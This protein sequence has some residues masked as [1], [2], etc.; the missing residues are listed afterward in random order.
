MQKKYLFHICLVILTRIGILLQKQ[1]VYD[2]II[3]VIREYIKLMKTL[4]SNAH[5]IMFQLT[6]KQRF[7][8]K[9]KTIVLVTILQNKFIKIFIH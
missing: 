8:K 3:S 7:G 1:R 4:L 9:I 5:A 6:I 2:K